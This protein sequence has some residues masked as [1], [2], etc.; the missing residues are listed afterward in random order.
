ME[1]ALTQLREV[2]AQT[3]ERSSFPVDVF[4]CEMMRK[5]FSETKK[6]NYNTDYLA[7]YILPA[8]G[9]AIGNSC[10]IRIGKLANKGHS[11]C[12]IIY[13][14]VVG[15]SGTGKTHPGKFAAKPFIK[16]D[17]ENLKE[18]NNLYTIYQEN[19]R[20]PKE[21]REEM[22][23]PVLHKTV[24]SDFTIESVASRHLGN[25]HSLWVINDEIKGF[26]ENFGRYSKGSDQQK[27]LEN[28][29]QSPM[30]IDRKNEG[31]LIIENPHISI[32]GGI[33][34]RVFQEL[35][36]KMVDDGMLARFLIFKPKYR[37]NIKL[38]DEQMDESVFDIWQHIIN[39]ILSIGNCN[40]DTQI[41]YFAPDAW[42][43]LKD[44]QNS[45]PNSD[46]EAIAAINSKLITYVY[47]FCLILHIANN[48][49]TADFT[50]EVPAY[51]VEDAIRLQKYFRE[52][53]MQMLDAMDLI[54]PLEGL[55]DNKVQL[56]AL[57]PEE[58]TTE[59][60]KQIAQD[61]DLLKHTAVSTF[62]KNNRLFARIRQGE[63]KKL[64]TDGSS[65]I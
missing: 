39:N 60:A 15:N 62:L 17:I 12:A 23:P 1:A 16:K 26:F 27:W 52:N 18:Y 30:I 21:E 45:Q 50:T 14:V 13:S 64:I 37:P 51:V 43:I 5:I 53:A 11:E 40:P 22:Q 24:M 2:L 59:K 61:N 25:P 57:L 38:T 7:G 56:Y 47:R 6:S 4:H 65:T 48:A 41:F 8:L 55:P 49:Y 35:F 20:K 9:T 32:T 44:W 31:S 36:A 42:E 54:S 63:Y 46:N 33:Q 34:P 29:S 28:F 58:F 19:L 10:R 3:F